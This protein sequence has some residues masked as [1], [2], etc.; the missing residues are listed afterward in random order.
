MNDH[1]SMA[2]GE[3]LPWPYRADRPQRYQGNYST[4]RRLGGPVDLEN[5]VRGFVAGGINHS[6]MA[7]FYFFCLAFDQIVKEDIKGDL[8][9]LGVYRGNTASLLAAIA[10]ARG[11][12]AYLLDTFT[13]FNS[14]D[15]KGIDAAARHQSFS[16]TSLEAVRTL[17]GDENVK[18]IQGYFP[19][20]A[21]QLPPHGDYCLVHIDCDLYLP[22]AS[23]LEY[24]YPRLVPGGYLIVHDY[25]SLHWNGAEKAVDE[26]FADKP[27]PII[28]LPDGA[29]SVAIR[30]FR[31]RNAN[32]LLQKRAAL[33][34]AE[35]IS[36]ANGG[37][38]DL[39]GS[40]WS[41]PESWG[42]WGVGEKHEL[43]LSFPAQRSH[44]FE[45]QFDTHVVMAGGRNELL[46]TVLASE[47]EVA[48]W[49]FTRALNRG[50]RTVRIHLE[51][52]EQEAYHELKLTLR[53]ASIE[54]PSELDP[55]SVERRPLGV[56]LHRIRVL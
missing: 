47:Q 43:L 55:M 32:W 35:W 34:R 5:F 37:I 3:A 1:R 8:V 12:T 4:Y 13:G 26:F 44:D 15:I 22:I 16:D 36:A 31:P 11:T 30:K 18:Y 19:D 17:V 28:P 14:K 6:D 53:P 2:S 27:E 29:G 38:R 7:R 40:G 39:L 49:R 41:G 52:K 51:A 9:E 42:V 33:L 50:V 24:F 54:A 10:R 21:S 25:S 48:N 46:V 23:A 56:A 20:T 45:L